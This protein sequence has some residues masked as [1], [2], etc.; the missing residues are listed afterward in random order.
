LPGPFAFGARPTLADICI[1]PQVFNAR[2]FGVELTPYPRIREIDAAA[3]RLEAFATAEP[4]R[5]P[6]AE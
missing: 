1:V 2:R 4:G 5:Q 3:A 6:D